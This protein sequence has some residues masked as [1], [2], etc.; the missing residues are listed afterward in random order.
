MPHASKSKC[1]PSGSAPIAELSDVG[2]YYGKKMS[3]IEMVVFKSSHLKMTQ[4]YLTYPFLLNLFIYLFIYFLPFH[5]LGGK[6]H[7][8]PQYR[9]KCD[10]VSLYFGEEE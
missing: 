9:V 5:L 6:R 10:S 4:T 8:E 7:M 2:I 1:F 3:S